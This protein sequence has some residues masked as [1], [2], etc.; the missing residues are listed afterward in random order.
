MELNDGPDKIKGLNALRYDEFIGPIVKAIQ[1]QNK[2][3]QD[4]QTTIQ[5]LQTQ[6]DTIMSM[7]GPT[8]TN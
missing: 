5:G 7:I 2:L 4:Q 6:I 3:I 1:E 8:G